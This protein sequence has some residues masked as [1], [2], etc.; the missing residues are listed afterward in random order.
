MHMVIEY[1][2]IMV[3]SIFIIIT[4]LTIELIHTNKKHT[5]LHACWYMFTQIQ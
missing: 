1:Q 4:A 2:L 3:R 5:I